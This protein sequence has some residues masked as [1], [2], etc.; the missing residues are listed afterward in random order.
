[1]SYVVELRDNAIT[2]FLLPRKEVTGAIINE[3]H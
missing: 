2:G 3:K 1:M